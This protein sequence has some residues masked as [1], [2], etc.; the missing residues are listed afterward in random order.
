[1]K[2]GFRCDPSIHW[3]CKSRQ[4]RILLS[5][6]PGKDLAFAWLDKAY[7]TYDSWLFELHDPIWDPLRNDPR[8]EDLLRRLNHPYTTASAGEASRQKE[9]AS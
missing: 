2:T 7:E 4:G 5:L 6:P 1:M 9:A 8:F 3:Q